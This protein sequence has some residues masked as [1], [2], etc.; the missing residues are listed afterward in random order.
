MG[1]KLDMGDTMP[2]LTFNLV[3]GG[4][5]TVPDPA[6]TNYQLLLFYRGHW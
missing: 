4:T 2:Q 6:I 5:A 3:G 1:A